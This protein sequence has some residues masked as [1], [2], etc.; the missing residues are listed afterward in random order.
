M[1]LVDTSIWLEV[2]RDTRKRPFLE[3]ALAGSGPVLTRFTRLALLEASRDEEEWD[4]L[5]RY[6]A[7]QDYLDLGPESWPAAVRIR[8]ELRRRGAEPPSAVDCCVAQVAI[9]HDVLLLH[10]RPSFQSIAEV[11]DL[12][13][14]RLEL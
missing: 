12:R 5:S 13:Q 7:V 14:R 9:E 2:L 10:T 8:F 11:R 6:L 1:I 3:A 4:L